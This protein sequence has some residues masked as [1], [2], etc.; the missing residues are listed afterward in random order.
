MRNLKIYVRFVSIELVDCYM[1]SNH[2]LSLAWLSQL[3][4]LK[5]SWFEAC[6][7]FYLQARIENL[8]LSRSHCVWIESWLNRLKV[9]SQSL[10]LPIFRRSPVVWYCVEIEISNATFSARCK[11]LQF[12]CKIKTVNLCTYRV[13]KYRVS[14]FFGLWYWYH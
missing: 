14:F 7:T 13:S 9:S 1:Q 12:A 6:F 8:E 4:L 10:P 3:A 5:S 11:D 2:Y